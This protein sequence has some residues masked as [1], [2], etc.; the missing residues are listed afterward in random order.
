MEKIRRFQ[1][2]NVMAIEEFK[3]VKNAFDL[4]WNYLTTF[5]QIKLLHNV[6]DRAIRSEL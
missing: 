3:L 5:V 2:V 1:I 6:K 4:F